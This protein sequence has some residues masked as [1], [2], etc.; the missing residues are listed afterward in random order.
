MATKHSFDIAL[1]NILNVAGFGNVNAE[2]GEVADRINGLQT[3]SVVSVGETV[4]GIE[5]I[6]QHPSLGVAKLTAS[7][8]STLTKTVTNTNDLA[9]IT[10]GGVSN[11][12]LNK[13]VTSPTAL[14]IKST[15]LISSEA[16]LQSVFNKIVPEQFENIVDDIINDDVST[17]SSKFGT[18]R[19][20]FN[21]DF[22]NLIREI[23]G[24]KTT[25]LNI[26][27]DPSILVSL[28]NLSIGYDVIVPVVKFCV[29]GNT[30]DAIN[31]LVES[32]IDV[33]VAESAVNQLLYDIRLSSQLSSQK[34]YDQL[35]SARVA[36][37]GAALGNQWKGAA[38]ETSTFLNITSKEELH[39]DFIRSSR[40]ITEIVFY[41]FE[42]VSGTMLNADILHAYSEDGIG[43]HYLVNQAGNLQRCRPIDT[44]GDHYAPH[45]NYSIA[46]GICRTKGEGITVTAIKTMESIIDAFWQTWPGGRVLEGRE[47][48]TD[49]LPQ[50]LSLD[51]SFSNYYKKYGKEIVGDISRSYSTEHLIDV[52]RGLTVTNDGNVEYTNQRA[53]RRLPVVPQLFNIIVTASQ[54]TGLNAV[55]FSGGQDDT[56]GHVGS[57]RHNSG[58]AADVNLYRDG[59]LL[60]VAD[61]QKDFEN[62]ARAARNAGASAIGAGPGYMGGT[63]MHIDI[64]AGNT[65]SLASATHWGASGKTAAAPTWLRSIMT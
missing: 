9:S 42:N 14:G 13:C 27:I 58:Y 21:N 50:N 23:S 63:G 43:I 54:Q 20:K 34:D 39:L 19:L 55:I 61:N 52:G 35:E 60:N 59:V 7:I 49:P 24:I 33:T 18:V 45:D 40:D 16:Q 5:V 6:A 26:R 4:D 31:L 53:T 65:V 8:D 1:K 32:D 48:I 47:I 2:S 37:S 64:A 30:N 28:T 51:I 25:D 44:V 22:G 46:V 3:T 38:T 57:D 11:G 15:N 56:T 12:F 62:F 41:C 36:V 29:D 17:I 10:G